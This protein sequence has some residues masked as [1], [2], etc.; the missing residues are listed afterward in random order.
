MDIVDILQDM[1]STGQPPVGSCS[2]IGV[3]YEDAFSRLERT[4]FDGF[5]RRGKSAEKFIIAPYGAGKTHFLR[6]LLELAGRRNCVTAEVPLSRNI[7]IEKPLM[8]YNEVA[9]ELMVPG[10]RLKGMS[11]LLD[12]YCRKMRS[13]APS[14]D[15]ED[16][17]LRCRIDA[18]ETA[19]IEEPRYR[20]AL[21]KTLH[22]KLSGDLDVFQC[23]CSW[24]GGEV[25]SGAIRRV[26]DID[27]VDSAERSTFGRRA[28]FSL[29]QFIKFAGYSGTVIGFDEA[30]QA[31]NTSKKQLNRILSMLRSEI[32]AVARVQDAAV[33]I[34]Y[35][36][37]PDVIQEMQVYPA[38]QQRTSEPDPQRKFFDGNTISPRIDL[39]QPFANSGIESLKFLERIGERLVELLYEQHGHSLSVSKEEALEACRN[40]AEEVSA[41]E[42]SISNRRYMVKLTASRLYHLYESGQIDNTFIPSEST[43]PGDAEV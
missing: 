30:E 40:W 28:L 5:D 38:L 10:Q 39:G 4:Y 26:L 27:S 24:L 22:A 16:E 21:M 41:R 15:L 13:E 32:D 34:V 31:R 25:S 37:I 43:S 8:V 12:A 1:A 23:G 6:Q 29:C 9:K 3:G 35:A 42:A 11:S 19:V 36:F 18:L 33:L 20:S 17:Y 2:M 7:P 14:P